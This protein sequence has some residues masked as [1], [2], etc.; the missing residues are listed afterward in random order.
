MSEGPVAKTTGDKSGDYGAIQDISQDTLNVYQI[1]FFGLSYIRQLGSDKM[2]ARAT[3]NRFRRHS[4]SIL[5]L[6]RKFPS[7][8]I[9]RCLSVRDIFAIEKLES[10]RR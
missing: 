4:Y 8:V 1:F 7:V 10:F 6:R 9:L 3:C 2:Y 5:S